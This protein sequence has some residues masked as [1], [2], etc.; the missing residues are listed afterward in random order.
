[1]WRLATTHDESSIV[2]FCLELNRED[3]GIRPVP[4]EY[5]WRTLKEIKDHPV[6]GKAYVL[7]LAEQLHGYA[8]LMSYWSNELGGEICYIDELYVA[9]SA[10]GQGHSRRLLTALA[11]RT[12]EYWPADCVALDLE[13]TPDNDGARRLYLSLGF[14]PWKNTMLRLRF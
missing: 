4:A 2:Q 14:R 6:R 1:M 8:L 13:V 11:G 9:P 12:G 5:A 10:R 7:E 3:P